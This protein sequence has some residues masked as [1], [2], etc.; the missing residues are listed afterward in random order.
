MEIENKKKTQINNSTHQLFEIHDKK[1]VLLQSSHILFRNC[2]V[3]H[4]IF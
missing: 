3:Y 1:C 2:S 4:Y